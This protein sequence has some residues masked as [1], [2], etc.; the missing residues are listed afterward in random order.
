MSE[1]I[2]SQNESI[3]SPLFDSFCYEIDILNWLLQSIPS[4]VGSFSGSSIFL[5]KNKPKSKEELNNYL[6][7][8]F[9]SLSNDSC[10]DPFQSKGIDD[11]HVFIMQ[12][13]NN[14]RATCHINTNAAF[15]QRRIL[16]CGLKGTLEGKKQNFSFSFVFFNFFLIFR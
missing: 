16:I 2:N 13:R 9:Q 3:I 10:T 4:K 15:P 14:V 8:D 1:W 11:N 5:P 6:N 12:Y 7:W